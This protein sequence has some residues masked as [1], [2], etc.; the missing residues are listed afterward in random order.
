MQIVKMMS[1]KARYPMKIGIIGAGKVG[2]TLGAYF[3]SKGVNI[4]GFSSL[5]N[6][7]AQEAA[8]VCSASAY[9]DAHALVET[10]NLILITVPD[11]E[12]INVYGHLRAY[13]LQ[14]KILVHC[15][16]AL[17]AAEGF[18]NIEQTGGFA[19]SMH[20]LF[21]I[22][23]R[24]GA[25]DELAAVHFTIEG[26][27]E[28]VNVVSALLESCGNTVQIIAPEMKVRYHTAAAIAS[29]HM[30]ALAAESL[31]LLV[32]CGFTEDDALEALRPIL[33]GN[34]RHIV[35]EGPTASLTGPIER[36]DTTTVKR[37]LAALPDYNSRMMYRL[38]SL[39]LLALA[40]DKHPER[41]YGPMEDLL[42][43]ACDQ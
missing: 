35:D 15:S 10:S 22:N 3:H 40:H 4:A 14:D 13:P 9:A 41:D 1:E 34:I 39:E 11:S 8:T 12:I 38:L 32:S 7:H 33:L 2:C 36:C 42:E 26:N 6:A 37:H 21:A 16:G 19:C 24:F 30:V 25:S 23:S 20:P 31:N 17:T 28:A 43:G 5:N 29:N 27:T 18:P